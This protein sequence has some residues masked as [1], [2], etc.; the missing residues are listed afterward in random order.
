MSVS[1]KD[2]KKLAQAFLRDHGFYSGEIDGIWGSLSKKAFERYSNHLA[3]IGLDIGGERPIL[4]DSAPHAFSGV[5][6]LDPGHGGKKKTGG[7]SPNNATS[8]SGVLEKEMTLDLAKRVKEQLK[9]LS[10][11]IP[12]SDIDVHLTRSKDV[13]LSLS[14]R[15]Q[16]AES[17]GADVFVSFHFNGFNR[18]ARGTE[19]W[20]LSKQNGNVNESE[21]RELA[22]RIQSAMFTAIRKLDANAR[23]R[24]IKDSQ[25]LGVLSDISLGNT[26]RHLKTRSCLTEVEFIDNPDVDELLNTGSRAVEVRDAIAESIAEAIIDDLRTYA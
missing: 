15:A 17:K 10:G 13:N 18:S 7:S 14:D 3:S 19:T 21:D 6:V 26:R 2:I 5:V 23:D 22:V 4:E 8:A 24:G 16:F 25:R 11:N 20:I 1:T 12:G 9:K